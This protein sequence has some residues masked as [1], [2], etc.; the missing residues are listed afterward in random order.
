MPLLQYSRDLTPKELAD[1]THKSVVTI[2]HHI[3]KGALPAY[4]QGGSVKIRLEDAEKYAEGVKI[5][6]E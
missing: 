1:L 4:K 2:R 3:R 5:S 6:V